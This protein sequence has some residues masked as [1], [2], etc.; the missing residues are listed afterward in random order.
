M[1][2]YIFFG[3]NGVYSFNLN[4]MYFEVNLLLIYTEIKRIL[5]EIFVFPRMIQKKSM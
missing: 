1:M 3:T 4:K 5:L 2:G